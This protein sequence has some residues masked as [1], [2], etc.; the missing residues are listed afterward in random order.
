MKKE[1]VNLA[2]EYAVASEL[3]RRDI[4][5]QVTMG[6]RKKCD[7]LV[8]HEGTDKHSI[9]EVKS[10]KEKEFLRIKGVEGDNFLVFVDFQNKTENERPDFYILNAKDWR[11]YVEKYIVPQ[12]HVTIKEPGHYPQYSDGWTGANIKASQL[13]EHKEKWEKI[14][15]KL[16]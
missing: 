13:F 16:S 5:A 15:N 6:N 14:T 1:N 9:I 11:T 7:L 12:G 8:C 2:G 4:L 3:F 10:K